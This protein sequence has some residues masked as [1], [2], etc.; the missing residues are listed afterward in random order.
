MSCHKPPKDPT[1]NTWYP[2]L[3]VA[4]SFGCLPC[5]SVRPG[6]LAASSDGAVCLTSFGS[7]KGL[8]LPP[9][10]HPSPREVP[11]VLSSWYLLG[12]F[13]SSAHPGEV[14]GCSRPKPLNVITFYPFTLGPKTILRFPSAADFT[15]A[16]R[17]V[18]PLPLP[19]KMIVRLCTEAGLRALCGGGRIPYLQC[20]ACLPSL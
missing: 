1:S 3:T 9:Y 7:E 20:P 15:V 17:V 19:S 14:P 6:D 10:I 12:H 5:P 16:V 4:C 13:P 8:P 18:L 2:H 11:E